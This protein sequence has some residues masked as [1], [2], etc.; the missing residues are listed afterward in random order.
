MTLLALFLCENIFIERMMEMFS[1]EVLEKIFSRE[2]VMKIPLTYQSV[3]VRAVQEV[4][5]K[6]G[7]DYA[8]KSLSEHEL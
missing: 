7:I 2:D 1:D 8:T 4:L 6:E 3:M 5:E